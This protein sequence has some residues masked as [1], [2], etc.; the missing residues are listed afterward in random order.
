MAANSQVRWPSASVTF[1]NSAKASSVAMAEIDLSV[2]GIPTMQADVQAGGNPGG[3]ASQVVPMDASFVIRTFQALQAQKF[4]AT[5]TP[6]SLAMNDGNGNDINIPGFLSRPESTMGPGAF[7]FGATMMGNIGRIQGLRTEIY[8]VNSTPIDKV[9]LDVYFAG[10]IASRLSGL[11]DDMIDKWTSWAKQN[12]ASI[13]PGTLALNNQIH[14]A[15]ATPLAIWK[16]LL[17]D[18]EATTK[19]ALLMDNEPSST[20]INY[21]IV[22]FI[23]NFYLARSENFFSKILRLC[24]SFKLIYVPND[25]SSDNPF[26]QLILPD[27]L[28][29][30]PQVKK[31]AIDGISAS[32]G[33]RDSMPIIGV[34]IQGLEPIETKESA[35]ENAL[36]KKIYSFWPPAASNILTQAGQ[37]VNISP[38]PW[39]PSSIAL[40]DLLLASGSYSSDI[41]DATTYGQNVQAPRFAAF[42]QLRGAFADIMQE[43]CRQNYIDI[44]LAQ[45]TISLQVP[46]DLATWKVGTRYT[47]QNLNGDQLFSGFLAGLRHRLEIINDR[48][49]NASTDLYF[50]YVTMG[51]FQLPNLSTPDLNASESTTLTA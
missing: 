37:I 1:N 39:M 36:L 17:Q 43:W 32:L 34:F 19:M 41:L 35:N 7:N 44:V 14:L 20:T 27:Y 2:N 30:H 31:V 42:V 25:G 12:P 51:D 45:D 15:N 22:N 23:H 13:D 16:R 21:E 10:S 28:F 8:N 29:N 9:K 40:N 18:S 47:I 49:G 33:S 26:G 24:E 48:Q 11:L 38:P 50:T 4:A 46:C 6:T 3:A 5:P